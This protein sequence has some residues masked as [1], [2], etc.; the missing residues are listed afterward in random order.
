LLLTKQNPL[1]VD[2]LATVFPG[3]LT[4]LRNLLLL[5]LKVGADIETTY[6]AVSSMKL[7]GSDTVSR[8]LLD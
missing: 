7:C 2:C 6:V 5:L 1:F 8:K 3:Y 4:G